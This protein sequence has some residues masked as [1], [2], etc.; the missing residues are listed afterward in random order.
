MSPGG[1][2]MIGHP[3]I[4]RFVAEG[5]VG[6]NYSPQWQRASISPWKCSSLA[7]G[8]RKR[9][10]EESPELARLHCQLSSTSQNLTQQKY[11]TSSL[12]ASSVRLSSCAAENQRL[13][14]WVLFVPFVKLSFVLPAALGSVAQAI[15]NSPISRCSKSRDPHSKA[16]SP[17]AKD[18]WRPHS[19][20]NGSLSR[21]RDVHCVHSTRVYPS[22]LAEFESSWV[23]KS[24]PSG[25]KV[26]WINGRRTPPGS[27][28][29]EQ[30]KDPGLANPEELRQA[31]KEPGGGGESEWFP[32]G[33][34]AA[35]KGC[36]VPFRR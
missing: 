5:E 36:S 33:S 18:S 21:A 9:T 26:E 31:G 16:G 17:K 29:F 6:V 27:R 8:L 19:T 22:T 2:L 12:C 14:K 32:R 3:S 10:L 4:E 34:C 23:S 25:R 24:S 35:S 1:L 28:I 7:G 13:Q 20:P 15:H 30:Q 11:R